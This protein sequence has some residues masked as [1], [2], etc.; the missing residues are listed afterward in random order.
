[1]KSVYLFLLIILFSVS[2]NIV[3]AQPHE[4]NFNESFLLKEKFT[5]EK[6][7]DAQRSPAFP[8]AGKDWRL[9][10]L[11][12][13]YDVSNNFKLDWGRFNDRYLMFSIVEDH[14]FRSSA[15]M[16]DVSNKR[17]KYTVAL[18]LYERDGRFVKIVS[19]WGDLIGFG[20][21]GFMYVQQGFYGTYFSFEMLQ[22]NGTI[23]YR[24]DIA[25]IKGLS[26]IMDDRRNRPHDNYDNHQEVRNDN[27]E[28][29]YDNRNNHEDRRASFLH[30]KYHIDQVWD[31]RRNPVYPIKGADWNLFGFQMALDVRNNRNFIDWGRSRDRYLMFELTDDNEHNPVAL[32]DD[33][34]RSRT[35]YSVSLKLYERDGLLVKTISKWGKLMGF[36][37]VGFMYEQEGQFGTFFST[38]GI[39]LSKEMKY[40]VDIAQIRFLSELR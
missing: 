8:Q 4:R 22:E 3:L 29:G 37:S 9:S 1:M 6:V 36:G 23:T 25:Q 40:R 7:W 13:A 31:V 5:R 27:R 14:S 16:D 17:S 32:M 33:V 24:P 18:T 15:F 30:K 11:K 34:N 2:S 21:S 28:P 10:G 20:S 38:D 39:L 35:R 26:E 12:T 19:K